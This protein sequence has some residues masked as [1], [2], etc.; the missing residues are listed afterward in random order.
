MRNNIKK[1]LLRTALALVLVVAVGA[2]LAARARR[3]EHMATAASIP[4][5]AAP[6]A[7]DERSLTATD[8]RSSAATAA[9]TPAPSA[10]PTPAPAPATG[11]RVDPEKKMI[12]LTFDDGPGAGTQRILSALDAVD[13]RATFCMVGNR[14]GQYAQTARR[15][16]EQGSEIATHTWDH[17][18]LAKL[19]AAQV[20]RELERSMDA[21]ERV[22]GVRP[23]V[24]RPPY[25][26]VNA[27]VRAAC[28]E[29]GLVIA[30]W[31]IDPEDWRVRDARQV[32]RHIMDNARDGAIVVCHDLY[33]ETAAAMESAVQELTERGYQLVTVSELLEA[34]AGGGEAGRLYYA[35]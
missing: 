26:S 4:V 16:A 10:P 9:P 19:S 12:A 33:P 1:K 18:N 8:E 2:A 25:G 7:T 29:L 14:V 31:N 23:T 28:R 15:V 21:I 13:G 30:N 11:R 27:T 22:T 20:Q 24:L 3:A 5:P 34:R 35:A 6:A 32:Y 17:P